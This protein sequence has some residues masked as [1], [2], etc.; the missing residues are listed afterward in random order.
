MIQSTDFFVVGGAGF[1]GSHLVDVLLQRKE[2][3]QVTLFDN[4]SS[5]RRWHYDHH[6]QNPRLRVIEGDVKDRSHLTVSLQGHDTVIHL[7][8][9]PDLS[10]AL[11]DPDIDFVD[12]TLLTRNVVEAMR[13]NKIRK[14]IY[15][16]GSGIY[17]DF[18]NIELVEDQTFRRPISTYAASKLA[19]EALISSYSFLFNWTALVFRF[20]NVVGPRQTHGVGF[21]FVKKLLSNPTT[22]EI[23]GDGSQSKSYIDVADVARAVLTANDKCED[24]QV[25]NVATDDSLSVREIA[26][27][28]VECLGLSRVH[29]KFTGGNRGWAGDIPI[30]RLNSDRIKNLGW[31]CERQ[32]KEAIRH[33]ILSMLADRKAMRL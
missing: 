10:K 14:I 25:F 16:S 20:A 9:N 11:K 1:I 4:F 27:L 29:Y 32:S 15:I 12:G 30:V 26:D 28:A 5:G 6:L 18:G 33:S 8:S 21:D 2:V 13:E 7:A 3:R 22:L 24:Y 23:L 17:G 31:K 19:G